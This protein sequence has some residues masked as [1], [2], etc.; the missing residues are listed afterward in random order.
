MALRPLPM[1][2]LAFF[3]PAFA[4]GGIALAGGGTTATYLALMLAIVQMADRWQK[5][6]PLRPWMIFTPASALIPLLL[7]SATGA[8][9][10]MFD[11]A[12]LC[13]IASVGTKIGR[14]TRLNS[15]H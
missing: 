2:W 14:A 8:L 15:S 11:L 5:A 1:G 4:L 10:P 7:A 3:A 12:M 13:A 6:G 9:A